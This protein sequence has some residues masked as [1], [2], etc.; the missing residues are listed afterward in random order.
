MI[1]TAWC[2]LV[3]RSSQLVSDSLVVYFQCM[4]NQDCRQVLMS[5][6]L[7]SPKLL[8]FSVSCLITFIFIEIL[9]ADTHF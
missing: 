5:C 3:G 4:L 9:E 7:T 1:L 8:S 2:L 6:G